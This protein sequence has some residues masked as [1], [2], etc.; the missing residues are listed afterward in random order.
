MISIYMPSSLAEEL[1]TM[2]GRDGKLL[3]PLAILLLQIALSSSDGDYKDCWPGQ[4]ELMRRTGI[5]TRDTLR[6]LF[7][8]LE[9]NQVMFVQSTTMK[10]DKG[11]IRTRNLYGFTFAKWIERDRENPQVKFGRMADVK[12]SKTKSDSR[13]QAE[14]K[15]TMD[16]VFNF[17]L[18]PEALRTWSEHLQ[19]VGNFQGTW[20]FSTKSALSASFVEEQFKRE[21]VSIKIIKAA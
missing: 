18:L 15:S 5:K 16:T 10:D 21:K 2:K 20:Y 9:F 12:K 6:K 4:S 11:N 1:P 8:D 13:D 19:P 17:D 14:N 7:G 3:S